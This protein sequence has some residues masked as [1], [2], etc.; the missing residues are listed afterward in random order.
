M[1]QA[2]KKKLKVLWAV[3]ILTEVDGQAYPSHLVQAFRIGRDTDYDF[4]LFTPRRM[5]I[6][7]ARNAAV[8]TALMNECDY[9]YFT[10]DD[11]E[12]NV[13]TLQTL[14]KRDKDIIMAMCYIRGLPYSPMV[15]KWVEQAEAVSKIADTK[16][17][18]RYITLWEDCEKFVNEDGLIENVAAV[19]CAATLIKTEV[20]KHLKAPW[21]YTG[22]SNTEDVY[23]C[24]KAQQHIENLQIAV[25]TTIP[26]GHVLKDKQVLYPNN[27]ALL[28]EHAKQLA[29]TS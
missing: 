25:D 2:E 28:R 8:E 5:S 23:F 17:D 29:A 10:D 21:F 6:A 20:F 9:I 1:V 3:N 13:N 12:L 24:M 27:A 4:M 22:T 16:L 19:G 11:M 7:N 18:G 14:V 26:A 15:F